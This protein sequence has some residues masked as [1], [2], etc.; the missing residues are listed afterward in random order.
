M[1]GNRVVRSF[2]GQ[3]Q[4]RHCST[5]AA[6]RGNSY[7]TPHTVIE[8][9]ERW[10]SKYVYPSCRTVRRLHSATLSFGSQFCTSDV[11][12]GVEIV[13]VLFPRISQYTFAELL[14]L[15]YS[16]V[17]LTLIILFNLLQTD[18]SVQQARGLSYSHTIELI[19]ST[20]AILW[21]YKAP[22]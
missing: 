1:K 17:L 12:Q 22:Q 18:T 9:S 8:A 4:H 10:L 14:M 13:S 2:G 6:Q 11:V 5:R 21:T 15:R 20:T 16:I 7:R 19:V 3:A